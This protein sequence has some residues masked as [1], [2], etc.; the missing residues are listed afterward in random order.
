[1]GALAI[2]RIW[3]LSATEKAEALGASRDEDL[4]HI[5][6][7]LAGDRAAFDELVRRHERP[8]YYLAMRYLHD[9]D[10]ASDIMQRT[11]VRAFEKL[12]DFERRSLFRTWLFRIAVNLCKNR[13]RDQGRWQKTDPEEEES[14][15]VAPTVESAIESEQR[16][17][18]LE[19][20][21]EK[22][23]PK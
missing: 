6:R 20:T 11:F 2:S 12:G 14:L 23:P 10:E 15:Q 5:D 7:F 18:M 4:E 13:I 9:H 19:Q 8:I 21:V 1:M 22:L 17:S 16:Q 3:L